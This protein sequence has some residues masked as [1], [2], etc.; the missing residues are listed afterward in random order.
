MS[1]DL[2]T[3]YDRM[4]FLT[5]DYTKLRNVIPEELFPELEGSLMGGGR[6]FTPF[7]N[8]ED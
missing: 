1:K 4:M 3:I 8:T 2:K 6:C 5:L 7:P